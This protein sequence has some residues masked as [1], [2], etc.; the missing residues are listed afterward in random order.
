[1]YKQKGFKSV[2]LTTALAVF[3]TTAFAGNTAE[4]AECV[5]QIIPAYYYPSTDYWTQSTAVVGASGRVMIMNPASGPGTVKNPDYVTGVA[6]AKAKKAIVVGYVATDY[7]DK[8]LATVKA[9]ILKYKNWYGVQGIFFDEASSSATKISYYKSLAQYVRE[10]G[11]GRV[12]LN[13][14]VPPAEGYFTQVLTGTNDAAVVFEGTLTTYNNWTQP[15]WVTK[16]PQ[17][18]FSHLIYAVPQANWSATLTKAKNHWAGFV[19]I[20]ND[21][22]TNPWDTLPPYWSAEAIAASTCI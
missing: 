13:P 1:M 21:N 14:G 8:P 17:K 18:K 6:A 9:E 20:T 10:I 15:S 2:S 12:I 11:A 19:Y 22:L 5:K 16:Y 4:A 7:G 3:V